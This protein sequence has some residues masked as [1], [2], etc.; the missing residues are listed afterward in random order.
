MFKQITDLL[1]PTTPK[2]NPVFLD[3]CRDIYRIWNAGES[4]V[5]VVE[6]D[7][8]EN[9]DQDFINKTFKNYAAIVNIALRSGK[10]TIKSVDELTEED[11]A[12][13][14]VEL[15]LNKQAS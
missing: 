12:G 9:I 7:I 1:K 15:P 3:K 10:V 6:K 11:Y 5:V 8:G 4:V 13:Y 2:T 14:I